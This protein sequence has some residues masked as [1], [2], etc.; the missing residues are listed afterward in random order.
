MRFG[1]FRYYAVCPRWERLC[2]VLPIIGGVIGGACFTDW[3]TPHS[4]WIG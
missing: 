4:Q 3:P 1:G 2:E